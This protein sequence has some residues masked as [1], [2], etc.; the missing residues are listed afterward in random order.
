MTSFGKCSNLR[1]D[2]FYQAKYVS[3][4]VLKMPPCIICWLLTQSKTK[5]KRN[6]FKVFWYNFQILDG[7]WKP[8]KVK[9]EK[10]TD[11]GRPMKAQIKEILNVWAECDRQVTIKILVWGTQWYFC[12][13]LRKFYF[14]FFL[15][16]CN[17]LN[18]KHYLKGLKQHLIICC[19]YKTQHMSLKLGWHQY[20]FQLQDL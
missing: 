2:I 12:M 10:D 8:L 1:F 4:F 11:Y 5:N 18:I 16:C 17:L 15:S 13:K 14:G 6:L 7:N 3:P 19:W 9:Y 20:I